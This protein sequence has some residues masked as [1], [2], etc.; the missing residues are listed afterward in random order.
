MKKIFTLLSAV[1]FYSVSFS[2]SVGIGTTSPDN[3]SALDISSRA[4]G[5]LI[6]RMTSGARTAISNPAK[7]L[8][9][10]DSTLNQLMV[11]M[12][13]AA[14]PN[15]QN[16][17]SNNSWGL[18]GNAN[19]DTT[20]N[21]IGT[22][23]TNPL[24]FRINNQ[25]AGRFDSLLNNQA[26][27][28]DG[29]SYL[30]YGAGKFSG[31]GTEN[32]AFG[33]QALDSNTTG[34]GNTALGAQA[35]TQSTEP[36]DQHIGYD[37]T[38]V[39]Y[40]AMYRRNYFNPPGCTATGFQA[41]YSTYGYSVSGVGYQ[42][43]PTAAFENAAGALAGANGDALGGRSNG[44]GYEAL[45][46]SNRNNI[47]ARNNIGN[48]FQALYRN[49]Q[50]AYN[51]AF[52]AGSLYQNDLGYSGFVDAAQNTAV[53]AF[54]LINTTHAE[55]NVALGYNAGHSYDNGYYNCFIGSETDAGDQ[56]YYNTIALGHGTI[57][58]A[59]NM[60][61]VGNGA[62]TSVGGLVGWSVISD[63]RVKKN[64]QANIPGL[65][66]INKLR[67]VTYTIDLA[68]IDRI[69]NP[70]QGQT[71]SL[72]S[73]SGFNTKASERPV[74]ALM[75]AAFKAKEQIL[76][77]GFVAQEVEQAAKSIN[78]NFSGVDAAKNDR[79]LYSLR[80]A[81]FAVPLIK[82]VQELALQYNDLKNENEKLLKQRDQVLGQL[83]EL[84]K[85]VR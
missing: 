55:G 1:C 44:I 72:S 3:S 24:F 70:M 40:Q 9:V 42:A 60:M 13:T 81:D 46:H 21:F 35:L 15:W 22:T 30:G 31:S 48:G 16:I 77:S 43:N 74:P 71:I 69:V 80:Y 62:T 65:A 37:N 85:K 78:Y 6:P 39:G 59:P 51:I 2:Q 73:E 76:Y 29:N 4:K 19:T 18:T 10:Y 28:Y 66:F 12:G 54:S 8:M 26:F 58:T 50:G 27:I 17:V 63:G 41:M 68:A 32:T 38:A 5:L 53:G 79:D 57:V 34:N 61:R 20:V 84:V 25:P 82:A 33:Y 23:D 47:Y 7:G 75:A 67:P 49:I 64:I 11:N 45:G 14:T 56:Q 36:T 83:Q 52:G